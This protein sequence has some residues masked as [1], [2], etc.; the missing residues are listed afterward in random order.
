MEKNI[1]LQY[2]RDLNEFFDYQ[3]KNHLQCEKKFSIDCN[4]SQQEVLDEVL[5]LII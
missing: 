4:L 5:S 3:F 2:L 1:S